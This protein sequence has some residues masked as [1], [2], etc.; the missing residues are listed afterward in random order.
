MVLSYYLLLWIE[1]RHIKS[2]YFMGKASFE[3]IVISEMMDIKIDLDHKV[4]PIRL[5]QFITICFISHL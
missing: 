4:I 3:V 5:L 2:H 1:L